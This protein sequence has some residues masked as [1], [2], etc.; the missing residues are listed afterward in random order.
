MAKTSKPAGKARA[1]KLDGDL[2]IG[3]V[4]AVLDALRGAADKPE[5]RVAL[6]GSQVDKVDAAGLQALLVGR[7]VLVQAGKTVSW[8]GSSAQL[9]A[10]AALLGLAESLELP[11]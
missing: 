6:D 4:A 8:S 5:K 9:K 2:R 7:Q 10:A 11:R 1:I 3:G